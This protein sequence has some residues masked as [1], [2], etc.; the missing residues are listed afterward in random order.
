MLWTR[1]YRSEPTNI[2]RP[3]SLQ[4]ADYLPRTRTL[5]NHCHPSHAG[6]TKWSFTSPAL[7]SLSQLRS[8]NPFTSSELKNVS[9]YT[10]REGCSCDYHNTDTEHCA[11]H[12]SWTGT[13]ISVSN[14]QLPVGGASQTPH[15]LDTG[16]YN[17][18]LDAIVSI[19]NTQ[20]MQCAIVLFPGSLEMRLSVCTYRYACRSFEPDPL[21]NSYPV[22]PEVNG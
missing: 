20:S 1:L 21:K 5:S 17:G 18:N 4:G 2:E 9:N 15:T 14:K 7:L 8:K 6:G 13:V 16:S 3:R 12:D 11:A 22:L 10:S 19:L